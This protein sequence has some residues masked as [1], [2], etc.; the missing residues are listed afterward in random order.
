[1]HTN[2]ACLKPVSL[3]IAY[4]NLART[5]LLHVIGSCTDIIGYVSFPTLHLE[6]ETYEA[7]RAWSQCMIKSFL[8]LFDNTKAFEPSIRAP[9]PY[10]HKL[11]P[12]PTMQIRN[13]CS[14]MNKSYQHIEKL[15]YRSFPFFFLFK[16]STICYW[17]IV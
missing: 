5:F 16:V 4:L 8:N 6:L 11:N 17:F 2:S 9:P 3:Q 1:M 7:I 12:S 14:I 15:H 10:E 13:H